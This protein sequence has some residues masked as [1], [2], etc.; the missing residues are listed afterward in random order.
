MLGTRANSD[1]K[2]RFLKN[3]RFTFMNQK[4]LTGYAPLGSTVNIYVN[5][6][7]ADSVVV[8]ETPGAPPGQG[9]YDIAATGLSND[10][11][12]EVKVVIVQPDGT[13]D[14]HIENVVGSS[15][16]LPKGVSAYALGVG[17]KRYVSNY[18]A[19]TY[20]MLAGGG[21]Y[22]GLTPN[23]TVGI[24]LATQNDYAPAFG[25]SSDL[26]SQSVQPRLSP[27]SYFGQTLAYRFFGNFLF[28][29]EEAVNYVHQSGETPAATSVGLDYITKRLAVSTYLFNYGQNYS[30]GTVNISN[31]RGFAM[32]G[33]P[34]VGGV[35]LA[36]AWAHIQEVSG[37]HSEDYVVSQANVP[38]TQARTQTFVRFDHMV[39]RNDPLSGNSY[40]NLSMYTFGLQTGPWLNTSFQMNYGV[41]DGISPISAGDL[42]YGVNVPLI[43]TVPTYGTVLEA[44]HVLN[45]YSRVN[46]IYRKYGTAQESAEMDYTRTPGLAGDLNMTF[47]Y[48]RYLLT[49]KDLAQLNLVYPF[50][51]RG[52]YSLGMNVNY[53][54]FTGS[55]SYDL[56]LTMRDLF[57]Y[58]RGTFGRVTGARSIYPQAGGLK[59]LVY[60]DANAN[61]RYDEGEPGVPG[62]QVLVDGETRF[63][64]GPSG[65]FFVGRRSYEDE[66]FVELDENSLPA[67]YT[68]TQGRQR[69][70]WEDYVFTRV[71][72]G[73]A[74]LDSISGQ[75][76]QWQNGALVRPIPG[77][78]VE[79][80]STKDG[81]VVSRSITDS[82][83]VYYLGQL[84]PGSYKLELE[85]DSVPPALHVQGELPQVSL[86]VST[87]PTD[88]K[89]VDIRL[90]SMH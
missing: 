5:G 12:N 25:L 82:G 74:V 7:L 28:K 13:R 38:F 21:Y 71:Y 61:G 6:R 22:Y 26:S 57:F 42:R 80:I 41:G 81:S 37:D 47:R 73:I 64:S 75:V 29:E 17:T 36:A 45:N 8:D 70:T 77:I 24:S 59:G 3:N 35:D 63:T 48:R 62:V 15:A 11:L 79:A 90:V 1:V 50:D 65:Y 67:T 23:A 49:G 83:G 78:T 44:S 58:D 20:G 46:V 18:S 53:S 31:R 16:L 55:T 14:E 56:Y 30:S 32:F 89:D 87:K 51:Q 88:L 33:A 60:L 10:V 76:V 52:R 34:H 43:T 19:Q 69:A 72:L 2:S 40:E 9:Q 66:T 84:K 4:H 39:N 27:R 86:P 68:P 54:G 85:K